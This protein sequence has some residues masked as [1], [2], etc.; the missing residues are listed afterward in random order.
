MQSKAA[1]PKDYLDSLPP[2]R[3]V[4]IS[5][6][7]QLIRKHLPR[8]YKETVAYGGLSY[9]IPLSLYPNTYNKQPLYYIG[10]ASQKNYC[11]LYLYGVYMVPENL[12]RLRAGFKAAGKRLDM[13]KSCV[14]FKTLDDLPLDTIA[15]SVAALTPAQYIER[16]EAIRGRR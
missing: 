5:R 15:E 16:Y 14:H 12:A 3:K 1:T 11:S 13:G 2:D 4:T 6:L 8:G 9:L 7:R 10:L